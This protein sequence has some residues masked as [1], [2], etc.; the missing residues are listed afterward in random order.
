MATMSVE[1]ALETVPAVERT[2]ERTAAALH[3]WI[4]SGNGVRR[5]I[6]D[7]LHGTWLGHPLHA[8]LTDVVLGAWT[9]ASLLDIA[10]PRDRRWRAARVP[11]RLIGIGIAAAVPTALAGATDFS[12]IPKRA[13][14]TGAV[15]A[16]LNTAAL[17]L[18][19]LSLW[20]RK[21][22]DRA[23]GI[24]LSAAGLAVVLASAWLGGELSYRYQVGVRKGNAP[25]GPAEWTPVLD[26]SLL[27]DR[28]PH[29]VEVAGT[30]VLL[31]RDGAEVTAIGAICSHE[32]GPL[33]EGEVHAGAVTCP[34]HQSVFNLRSGR[35]IH[36]P[37][38]HP[39]PAYAARIRDGKVEVRLGRDREPRA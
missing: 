25:D 6:A 19:G 38:T 24:A 32:G 35:V 20:R 23:G 11:D 39:Q 12:A 13:A 33:D 15:H 16:M 2:A 4:L 14:A 28:R 37:A 34:W 26:V 17:G 18:Y 7:V 5:R 22:G 36:G 10:G 9:V 21:Q 3:D 1:R 31:Y 30:P 8:A 27:V 29:R